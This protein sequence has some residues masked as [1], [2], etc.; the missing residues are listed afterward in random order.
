VTLNFRRIRLAI[1]AWYLV[2][3]ALGGGLGALSALLGSNLPDG[4]DYA[5]VMLSMANGAILIWTVGRQNRDGLSILLFFSVTMI[6][7][8]TIRPILSVSNEYFLI[9]G[10]HLPFNKKDYF[11]SELLGVVATM[12]FLLGYG[13][14]RRRGRESPP[15]AT[16][17]RPKAALRL[18]AVMIVWSAVIAVVFSALSGGAL[19]MSGRAT[20]LTE[21][22]SGG[23][24][25]FGAMVVPLIFAPALSVIGSRSSARIVRKIVRGA[26]LSASVVILSLLYQRGFVIFAVVGFLWAVF[27]GRRIGGKRL[28]VYGAISF[29]FLLS[30]RP[31]VNLLTG[32]AGGKSAFSGGSVAELARKEFL[33]SPNFDFV[34][35]GVRAVQFRY[36]DPQ[37]RPAGLLAVPYRLLPA[38]ERATK[39]TQSFGTEL[40]EAYAPGGLKRGFGF[41]VPLWIELFGLLGWVGAGFLAICGY[42]SGRLDGRFQTQQGK[43]DNFYYLLAIILGGFVGPPDGMFQWALVAGCTVWVINRLAGSRPPVAPF[44]YRVDDPRLGN[45]F[46]TQTST[47]RKLL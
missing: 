45:Y 25:L 4:Y 32:S 8:Y 30:I 6:F 35:V 28:A 11:L 31:A 18:S 42:F 14:G 12:A 15:T 2:S 33:F 9:Y 1:P 13:V 3:L 38:S 41:V 36:V 37:I 5:I 40:N 34:D 44:G 20:S 10:T 39:Q 24:Y 27:A 29:A 43:G 16:I 21:T 22:A 46:V 19:F 23:K 17:F 26:A 7:A 47:H